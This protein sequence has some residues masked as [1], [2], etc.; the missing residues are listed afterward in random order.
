MMLQLFL[1]LPEVRINL[2][3]DMLVKIDLPALPEGA[4]VLEA[5]FSALYILLRD[6][7]FPDDNR[8]IPPGPGAQ[9]PSVHNLYIRETL[10]EWNE[11]TGA[12]QAQDYMNGRAALDG[13][14]TW[15]SARHGEEPWEIPGAYGETDVGP[16]AA[17]TLFE[18]ETLPD[19]WCRSAPPYGPCTTPDP[20][21]QWVSFDVTDL[22]KKW[23][24]DPASNKGFKITQNPGN[25]PLYPYAAG[26][27]TFA[28]S[29]SPDPYKH[30]KLVIKY[31]VL[32]APTDV[33]CNVVAKSWAVVLTWTNNG[34]PYDEIRI[35]RDGEV[36]DTVPG[37]TTQYTDTVENPG[38]HTYQIIATLDG[39]GGAS[40]PCEAEVTFVP[41]VTITRCEIDAARI[42]HLEW[43]RGSPVSAYESVSVTIDDTDTTTLPGDAVSFESAPLP[44]GIHTFSVTPKLAG[45]DADP[46]SCGDMAVLPAP[47]NLT[48][49]NGADSWDVSLS[50][51]N[52]W[53]YDS[54]TV[55]RDGTVLA[56]L[57]GSPT[58]YTDH[59]PVPGTYQYTV[60]GSLTAGGQDSA[61]VDCN[62][63]I[64]FV[65]P[66]TDI[67]CTYAADG[68]AQLSWTNGASNYTAIT[69]LI[70]GT[71]A[72]ES[73]L[74]GDARRGADQ[75]IRGSLSAAQTDL[76]GS[77]GSGL[78]SVGVG[79]D[80]PPGADFAH[81]Q[82]G[83]RLLCSGN[84]SV[85]S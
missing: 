62:V 25:D 28:S 29:D 64:T 72:P 17:T 6:I 43:T 35:E 24:S 77:C 83:G 74:S 3:K 2:G 18:P 31:A 59:V 67:T 36:I 19:P 13:E 55:S 50:W 63:E 65:P 26:I 10:R 58:S 51:T 20:V 48:C 12:D 22:V 53:T 73:P 61:S 79:L 68:K 8:N 52:G 41:P 49:E 82:R 33:A 76:P 70:D 1:E 47:S 37:D 15:N 40:D 78:A 54:V 14:V 30:P 75:L 5:E 38:L 85:G 84:T 56:V 80:A 39:V 27:F 11:G 46:K 16:I 57:D 4:V 69:L 66:V 45:Y 32:E 42:A 23:I 71:A 44:P 60:F 21:G 34:Y 7:S 81:G 9:E